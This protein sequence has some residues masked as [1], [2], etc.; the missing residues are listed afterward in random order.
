MS[1]GRGDRAQRTEGIE[2]STEG[3]PGPAP[4][5]A[6]PEARRILEAAAQAG[7]VLRALG[8]VAVKLRCPSAL[9]HP[10]LVRVC[11]DID[12]CTPGRDARHI[13]RLLSGFSYAPVRSFNALH[14]ETRLMFESG[15]TGRH[16]DV[17]IDT[18]EMCHR[19]PLG[20]RLALEP[21]TLPLA[22]LLLTKLQA[23]ELADKDVRDI[24]AML[25]DH[26]VGAA[27]G[28]TI[29]VAHIAALLGRDWGLHRTI[30]GNL[31]AFIKLL[32]AGSVSLGGP[33]QE[34]I[35]DRACRL[36]DGCSGTRKGMRWH[37]RAAVG[38][39]VGWRDRP[40]PGRHR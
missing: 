11:T 37:L 24:V 20:R 15:A 2:T 27:D 28:E 13:P 32:D 8:G 36:V 29:N 10:A 1:T 9:S 17:F 5:D 33:E 35:V 34:C 22:E 31:A 25:L 19:I 12:L 21:L 26:D 23:V 3:A 7:V 4:S 39:R 14:G 30:T 38:E 6:L 40:E 16:L 18:F